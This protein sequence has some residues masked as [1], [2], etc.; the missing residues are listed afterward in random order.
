MS[1]VKLRTQEGE[2]I[3][4][5]EDV[6]CKS[7]II[8][9]MVEESG[10]EEEVPVPNVKMYILKKVMEYCEKHRNDE[11]PEIE[12]PLRHSNLGELVDPFDAKFIEIENLEELFDIIL[13][14]NYLNIKSL[15]DLSCAKVATLIKGKSPEEIRKT[16]NIPND[17]TPEEEA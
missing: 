7:K 11:P 14:A 5:D 15:L 1:K 3:E 2:L 10:T 12:K 6:A 4:V 13:A 16:F 8:K 17:F 9:D